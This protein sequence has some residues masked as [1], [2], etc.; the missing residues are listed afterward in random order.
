MCLRCSPRG[1]ACLRRVL[2]MARQVDEGPVHSLPSVH[3]GQDPGTSWIRWTARRRDLRCHP[4]EG[5]RNS[6]RF[7]QY[8]SISSSWRYT[9]HIFI[10][11]TYCYN[12]S[13]KQT[14]SSLFFSSPEPIS[15]FFL[16][17]IV[18]PP[19]SSSNPLFLPF[20]HF[21]ARKTFLFQLVLHL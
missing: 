13:R 6:V 5:Q 8:Q 16:F 12:L 14:A 7:Y 2:A 9:T 15:S 21:C 10:P 19:P 3:Q 18:L 17:D 11:R 1:L 20:L 4:G